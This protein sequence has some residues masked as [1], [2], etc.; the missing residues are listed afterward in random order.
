M[1]RPFWVGFPYVGLPFGVTNR[2]FGRYKLSS[3]MRMEKVYKKC[4]WFDGDESHATQKNTNKIKQIHQVIQF[5]TF[6]SP[7]WR[8]RCAF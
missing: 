7:S 6:W 1:F 2:R 8:S 5:V 4:W 3:S